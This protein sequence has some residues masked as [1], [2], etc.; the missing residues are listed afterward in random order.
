MIA[1]LRAMVAMDMALDHL[2]RRG[3][4][5]AIVDTR[6]PAGARDEA[7]MSIYLHLFVLVPAMVMLYVKTRAGH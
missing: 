5:P 2:L 4:D 6:G 3:V 1:I 7:K